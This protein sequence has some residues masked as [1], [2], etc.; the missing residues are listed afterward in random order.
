M[1]PRSRVPYKWSGN[2]PT[3]FAV[4]EAVNAW[5]DAGLIT[6]KRRNEILAPL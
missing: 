1:S 5:K 3:R 6:N 4:I 2:L